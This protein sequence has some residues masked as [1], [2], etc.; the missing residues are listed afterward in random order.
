MKAVS[1]AQMGAESEPSNAVIPEEALPSG[2]FRVPVP[3]DMRDQLQHDNQ[4]EGMRRLYYYAN[5]KTKQTSWE[6]PETDPYFLQ[7]RF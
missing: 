3:D 2:W 1:G 6:R 5:I 4:A 7:V